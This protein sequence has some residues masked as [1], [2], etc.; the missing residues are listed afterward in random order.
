MTDEEIRL[1][2]ATI[3]GARRAAEGII[4]DDPDGGWFHL[5]Y[6]APA[7]D[8]LLPEEHMYLPFCSKK[9]I[10]R[11]RELRTAHDYLLRIL[12]NAIADSPRAVRVM[13]KRRKLHEARGRPWSL[14]EYYHSANG[15]CRRY[16]GRLSR[17]HQRL[18]KP[19][20]SGLALLDEANAICRKS[21]IGDVVIVSER[22]RHFFYFMNVALYG[23]ALGIPTVDTVNAAVIALRIMSGAEADDFDLDPRG[24][25]PGHIE[26]PLQALTGAQLEF[27][28]GHEFA[29]LILGH[30][31]DAGA[32]RPAKSQADVRTY[33]HDLEHEA[34]LH[35]VRLAGRT[36]AALAQLSR[37]AYDV[38]LFLYFL[39][40]AA[41]RSLAPDF[42][43]SQTH[44]GALTRLRHLREALG[45]K[46]QPERWQLGGRIRDVHRI[47]EQAEHYVAHCGRDDMLNFYGSLYLPSFISRVKQDRIDF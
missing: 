13:A 23:S 41:E 39:E 14:G 34:D 2:L 36:K 5:T 8:D 9:E 37:A 29:H 10:L 27:T 24:D 20:P 26:A 17:K 4:I 6:M 28:F 16:V 42:S 15:E 31:E 43:V 19:L 7:D 40:A 38:L 35:S 11:M 22:L 45:D 30:L 33:C 3:P 25:V 47:V 1:V 21:L 18:V 32:S 44:P 12:A 46:H